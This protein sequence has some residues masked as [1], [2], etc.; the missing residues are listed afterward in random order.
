MKKIL[1]MFFGL[2][3]VLI[4]SVFILNVKAE[5]MKQD[6]P[7]TQEIIE[8][9]K[10]NEEKMDEANENNNEE[11]SF[12][13]QV[14]D[15]C[16]KW[17]SSVISALVGIFGSS[18]IILLALRVINKMR[19]TVESSTLLG[20]EERQN[21]LN[22]LDNARGILEKTNKQLE[23]NI[24]NY[25][26]ISQQAESRMN[27]MEASAREIIAKF[28]IQQ[29]QIEKFKEVIALLIIAN[30]TLTADDTAS[31][32]LTLLN[33]EGVDNNEKEKD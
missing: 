27:Q 12:S 5:E 16:D 26:D 11:V 14:A 31:K 17:L 33:S 7:P 28:N 3:I 25:K 24:E 2:V 15:W 10:S 8:E 23:E 4:M 22:N 19:S 20:K 1:M 32:I 30:P 6:T 29:E 21:V 13:D 18:G 9:E